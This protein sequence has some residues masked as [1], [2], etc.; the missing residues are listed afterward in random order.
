MLQSLKRCL[1]LRG[2]ANSLVAQLPSTKRVHG[3]AESIYEANVA[4]LT[5]RDAAKT[6][7]LLISWLA[8]SIF[9]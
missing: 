6:M 8:S 9:A 2:V 7:S 5:Y 4:Q 1:P 3:V